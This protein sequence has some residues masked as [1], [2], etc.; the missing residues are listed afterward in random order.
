MGIAILD[1]DGTLVDT[2]Y[3]HAIAWYRAYRTHG[4]VLPI[5]RI[6]RHIGMGGDQLV[7]A[8]TD[9]RTENEIS[10]AAQDSEEG[11]YAELIDELLLSNALVRFLRE[12]TGRGPTKARTTIRENIVVVMLGQT[13]TNGEQVLEAAVSRCWRYAASTNRRCER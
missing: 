7:R 10:D 13:L 6:H 9:E 5:W 3:H 2:N 12:Y 8:L 4:I 1:I 11:L